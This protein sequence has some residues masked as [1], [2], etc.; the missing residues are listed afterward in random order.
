MLRKYIRCADKANVMTRLHFSYSMKL[1]YSEPVNLCHFTIKCLPKDTDR[2]KVSEIDIQMDPRAKY[3]HSQ[4]GFKND[5]IIGSLREAHDHYFL[6]VSGVV[7]IGQL[8]YEEIA[9]K[10]QIG[11][12]R[13]PYGKT[14]PGKLILQ[15][16]DRIN[17]ELQNSNI[18]KNYDKAL[19][20]MHSL[21]SKFNYD[22][23]V[24][25]INTSAE[26]ALVI[27]QGVCQ[28]YA[29]IYIALARALG[30]PAR[31]VT[32]LMIG[33]GQSHAWVEIICDDKW[34]G[35]DPTNDLLIDD[36][37]I[38][39]GNGRDA[40]DCKINLGIMYGGGQQRQEIE[41]KVWKE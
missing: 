27:G 32:G 5:K 6:E 18:E 30:I 38:K 7:E 35:L 12:Y 11:M 2:Q 26:E 3:S 28:D 34:I 4:D 16:A 20:I 36:N 10:A 13:Y 21:H 25:D 41:V 1:Y 15:Y 40:G 24:T 9:D 37:Y 19:Y 17:M 33:E 23:A 8:L 14:S 31:Y 22:S 39:L 29:H